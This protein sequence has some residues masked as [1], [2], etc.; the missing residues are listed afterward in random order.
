MAKYSIKLFIDAI[1]NGTR[2]VLGL[3]KEVDRLGRKS[4]K[5][6]N[7]TDRLA[8]SLGRVRAVSAKVAAG[9]RLAAA[10]LAAR[11]F[12][13][14][15]AEL[16]SLEAGLKA[17]FGS[18]RAAAREMA[19]VR[20]V[21][22]RMGIGVSAAAKAYLDLAAASKGTALEGEQTRRIFEAISLAMGKLGK[23][24]ADTQGALQAVQQMIS[25]GKVSAEELRGQL[26]ER[27][28]GAF[29]AAAASIGVTTAELDK[30]LQS[31]QLTAETLLP[32]LA[33]E[34]NKLYNSGGEINTLTAN[35]NRLVNAVQ[36]FAT[37]AVD[38]T[39][40]INDAY[41][42]VTAGVKGSSS[43]ISS[44]V[45]AMARTVKGAFG[46]IQVAWNGL[47][48]SIKTVVLA[49]NEG[50]NLINKGMAKITFGDVSKQW[51]QAADE[52][53]AANDELRQSIAED[54]EDIKTG[55]SKISSAYTGISDSA[56]TT[57]EA[58]KRADA[59]LKQAAQ[60]WNLFK[61]AITGNAAVLPDLTD[62]MRDL[63][64]QQEA[65]RKE[66]EKAAIAS[67]A[68]VIA[69]AKSAKSSFDL[70]LATVQLIEQQKKLNLEK[71]KGILS[72]EQYAKEIKK[73]QAEIE[74]LAE[75][76]RQLNEEKSSS[77]DNTK[78]TTAAVEELTSVVKEQNQAITEAQTVMGKMIAHLQ[79]WREEMSALSDTAMTAFDGMVES[80]NRAGGAMVT[81]FDASAR[82]AQDNSAEIA[83]LNQ[84]IDHMR[85]AYAQAT[86]DVN[87]WMIA[88]ETA[89]LVVKR[90]FLAQE[91]AA[92]RLEDRLGSLKGLT[93]DQ[94]KSIEQA[95]VSYNL[96]DKARLDGIRAQVD[97]LRRATE[98]LD[99]SALATLTSL[100]NELD[101][102]NGNLLAIENRQYEQKRLELL[103]Q[104][105]AA[106]EAGDALALQRLK[107][108]LA[109]LEK[110]HAIKVANLKADQAAAQA[111]G[112]TA[113][114]TRKRFGD[115]SP[116]TSE[117]SV[118][119][120]GNIETTVILDG[121]AIARSIQPYVSEFGKLSG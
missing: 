27:L 8:S 72:E 40:A 25:K 6:S 11:A 94:A 36:L 69:K 63:K 109:L 75:K 48:I 23:S 106:Q 62:A 5:T 13:K 55:L 66:Q 35:W 71:Q 112:T 100:Q 1:V 14:T 26:G 19:Y 118:S 102:L 85:T 10:A 64:T 34:L 52:L 68:D 95:L 31:G 82:A 120:S 28:P 42:E 4:A 83:S 115:K 46:A 88:V 17:V 81:S 111:S 9:L 99:Q 103:E 98:A 56:E 44:A 21:A 84:Q 7:D 29:Q 59:A 89:G 37:D 41:K 108:S 54:V 32:R 74:S 107:E 65:L 79:F 33:T 77:N 18:S 70:A 24:S 30:M 51:K 97:D 15:N 78:D 76:E 50:I 119:A 93:E 39:N 110:I 73:V 113:T 47:Q 92:A 105:N 60:G 80:I 101:R 38:A 87:R 96:L 117:T 57:A 49:I 20:D 67:N 90:S 91:D 2:D 116:S 43:E 22:S 61:A 58:V 3:N 104:I 121:K 86:G 45:S 114:T 53:A 12:V 16:Q